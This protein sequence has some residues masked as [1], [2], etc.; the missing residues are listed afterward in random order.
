MGY[1]YRHSEIYKGV[2]I[3]KRANTTKELMAKVEKKR[4]EID[5]GL[6]DSNVPLQTYALKWLEAYKKPNVSVS[7]YDDIERRIRQLVAGVGNKPI[8]KITAIELQSYLNTL[9]CFS[10]SHIKKT[11]DIIN[12]IFTRAYKDGLVKALDIEC[13]KGQKVTVGRSLTDYERKILLEVLESHRGELFC[14]LMLFCGLRGGEVAALQWKDINL[15]GGIIHVSKAMKKDGTIGE[16]KTAAG[17]RD[18]PIPYSFITELKK[19]AKDPFSFVCIN[20][21]GE[22]Y[23]RTAR[24]KL[25]QNIKREMNIKMGCKVFRNQL[26]PPFPLQEPFKMHYLRHT[27]CTDL[28]KAGV[29]INIAKVLM[30]HSS[31][32]VTAQIYTHADSSTLEMARNL[33]NVANGMAKVE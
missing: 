29:P 28:E 3:D 25:W 12:Q 30:G 33:I 10:D 23:T 32:T 20:T 13:P 21:K 2:R 11:Y 27:Y 19:S 6:I 5:S 7:W 18:V 17:V 14:K 24:T 8:G 31:I 1:K 16:P 15:K 26:V 9:T 4:K 22:P